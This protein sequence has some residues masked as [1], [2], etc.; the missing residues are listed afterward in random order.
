MSNKEFRSSPQTEPTGGERAKKFRQEVR[1][2]FNAR[3]DRS[4][5]GDVH[6]MWWSSPV[7]LPDGR[8]VRSIAQTPMLDGVLPA[9]PDKL[10]AA[11]EFYVM[12]EP[13]EK[14]K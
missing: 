5:T 3:V 12:P 9:A 4:T 2:A 1:D 11:S 10:H 7:K 13:I 14:K 6:V 8:D